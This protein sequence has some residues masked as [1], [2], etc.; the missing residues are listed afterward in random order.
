VNDTELTKDPRTELLR[1]QKG[2]SL[3]IDR[4]SCNIFGGN[5]EGVTHLQHPFGL[6]LPV[7]PAGWDRKISYVGGRGRNLEMFIESIAMCLNARQSLPVQQL[8]VITA[9][10]PDFED[11]DR[12]LIFFEFSTP[13]SCVIS[14]PFIPESRDAEEV[15]CAMIVLGF[16]YDI[17]VNRHFFPKKAPMAELNKPC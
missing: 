6:S 15:E 12:H 16:I 7:V 1:L 13:N 17:P 10:H 14:G 4:R 8:R 11:T 3:L 5:D 2:F 9:L